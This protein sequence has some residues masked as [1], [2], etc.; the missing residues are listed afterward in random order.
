LL[1]YSMFCHVWCTERNLMRTRFGGL[2]LLIAV[3]TA[4]VS[5][6]IPC[7]WDYPVWSKSKRS[8]TPLF[9]FIANGA[10][11]YIDR[12]GAIVI[13][14]Q[15]KILGNH[16]GDFFDGLANVTVSDDTSYYID[17]T[18]KRVAPAH[19]IFS[20]DFFEHLAT[21]WTGKAYGYI[22]RH[23]RMAIPAGFLMVSEFREHRA[24][25]AVTGGK[26]GYIDPSGNF[27]IAPKFAW[28]E[29]FFDGVARVVESGPCGHIGYGPCEYPL[30]PPDVVPRGSLQLPST[31]PRCKYSLIDA[32]GRVLFR[33]D[34]IDAKDFAE[35][36]A[37]VG[38]GKRWGY[39]DKSGAVR[40]PLRYDDAEPFSDG[41]ARVRQGRQWGYINASGA[42]VI[43]PAFMAAEDFSE[44]LAVVGDGE[45]NGN[46]PA[47]VE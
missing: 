10:A 47:K 17:S 19:Y 34:F 23:G 3:S 25:V 20:G 24:A 4:S 43:S 18:G 2:R 39:I 45:N 6:L 29:S 8:N 30:N 12:T 41:L 46:I 44:G 36:L 5:A 40:I 33:S 21:R 22:D 32:T 11:G 16:G 14:A 37:P 31:V 7:S 35:G 15:F 28:A 38:D 13:P 27:L 1:R 42:F 9:R 26:W